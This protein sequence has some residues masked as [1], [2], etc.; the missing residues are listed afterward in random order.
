MPYVCTINEPQMIALH[1]YLEGYHP[2]GISNPVLWK[3]AGQA[4]LSV[5][6]HCVRELREHTDSRIG[7]AV[8]LPLLAPPATTTPVALC[9]S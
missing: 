1:G 9:T 6:L 8:Q 2:P 4:L 5:H 3:R 7:L